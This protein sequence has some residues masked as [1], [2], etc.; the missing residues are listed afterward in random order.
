MAR[1]I[2]GTVERTMFFFAS[3]PEFYWGQVAMSAANMMYQKGLIDTY[4]VSTCKPRD[5]PQLRCGNLG[6]L[7]GLA[8]TMCHRE[9][10]TNARIESLRGKALGWSPNTE[11][12]ILD[13]L[14]KEIN[15]ILQD[16]QDESSSPA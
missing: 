11:L 16:L 8:D 14:E 7:R 5:Y 2:D 4:K 3:G 10:A 13:D 15:S 6:R 1:P 12:S 9:Y